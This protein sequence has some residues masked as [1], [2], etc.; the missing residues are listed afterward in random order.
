MRIYVYGNPLL[1]QDSAALMLIPFL[2]KRFPSVNFIPKDTMEEMEEKNPVILDVCEGIQKTTVV[3][4]LNKLEI[5]KPKQMH[6]FDLSTQL[7]L[8]L[9][10]GKIKGFKII[11]VPQKPKK[12]EVA[13]TLENIPSSVNCAGKSLK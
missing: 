10:T 13:K 2:R 5:Y 8:L 11:C 1:P 9:K 3:D 6:D 12:E 4:D 7:A